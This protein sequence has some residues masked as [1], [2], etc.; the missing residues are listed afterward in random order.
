MPGVS[1]RLP[2]SPVFISPSTLRTDQGTYSVEVSFKWNSFPGSFRQILSC[3]S[4]SSSA[5]TASERVS[6]P[7]LCITGIASAH[8]WPNP[9]LS[10]DELLFLLLLVLSC[11]ARWKGEGESVVRKV[12]MWRKR[13]GCE[14]HECAM[15]GGYAGAGCAKCARHHRHR[16]ED[17]P[18]WHPTSPHSVRV[19]PRLQRN[20]A[21]R[22]KG[23]IHN[24][25]AA[26]RARHQRE[27]VRLVS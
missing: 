25:R 13:I 27:I 11:M 12:L 3:T 5:S 16:V 15:T 2:S 18:C 7:P 24:V 26:S 4:A 10:K 19:P 9:T 8:I 23:E 14:V 17:D 6:S 1:T 21:L 22:A 20:G